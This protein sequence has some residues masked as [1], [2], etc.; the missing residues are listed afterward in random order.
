MK[1]YFEKNV[2]NNA[3]GCVWDFY[4]MLAHEGQ[5]SDIAK[6]TNNMERL[7]KALKNVTWDEERKMYYAD[8][9]YY[10]EIKE[11]SDIVEGE[12]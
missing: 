1:M 8:E 5:D 7:E 3:R 9:V 11:A 2:F 10:K 4:S 12:I 6:Y